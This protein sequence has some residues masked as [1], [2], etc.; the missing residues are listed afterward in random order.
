MLLAITEP[1][2]AA[3][4]LQLAGKH[5]QFV[6]PLCGS[7]PGRLG[8]GK[9]AAAIELNRQWRAVQFGGLLHQ[10]ASLFFIGLTEKCQGQMQIGSRHRLAGPGALVT[11]ANDG[12]G[13][14]ISRKGKKESGHRL[15]RYR[16]S[17]LWLPQ[18]KSVAS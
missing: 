10:F 8:T 15:P 7:N 5:R 17:A 9:P 6:G 4:A 18:G 16:E 2:T 12:I 13:Q 1:Q 11:P 3:K 14:I